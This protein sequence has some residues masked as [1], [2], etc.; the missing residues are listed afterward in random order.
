[1]ASENCTVWKFK[2]LIGEIIGDS[3]TN[4][5]VIKF[6]NPVDDAYNGKSLSDMFFY[7]GE[8]IKIAQKG[9]KLIPKHSL[10]NSSGEDISEKFCM[11]VQKWFR[12]FCQHDRLAF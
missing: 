9:A 8:A 12:E 7:D 2:N 4:I 5:D 11:I 1:M 10:M 3:P 6:V